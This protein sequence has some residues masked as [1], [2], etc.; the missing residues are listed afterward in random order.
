MMNE[1]KIMKD[2]HEIRANNYSEEVGLSKQEISKKRLKET[3]G[4][5]KIIA[6]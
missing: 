1:S 3:Q 6:E 5:D 4:V 2:I